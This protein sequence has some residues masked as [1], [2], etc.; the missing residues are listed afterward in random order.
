M[1]YCTAERGERRSVDL[2]I[3]THLKKKMPSSLSSLDISVVESFDMK[4]YSSES[5]YLKAFI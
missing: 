4:M 3:G 2:V 5:C 1:W